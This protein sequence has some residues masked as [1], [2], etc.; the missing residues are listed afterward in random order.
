[1][2]ICSLCKSPMYGSIL[3]IYWYIKLLLKQSVTTCSVVCYFSINVILLDSCS[4]S[5]EFS[6]CTITQVLQI[7]SKCRFGALLVFYQQ[8]ASCS[9]CT[10]ESLRLTAHVWSHGQYHASGSHGMWSREEK[11]SK[12]T[13]RT[14][15]SLKYALMILTSSQEMLLLWQTVQSGVGGRKWGWHVCIEEGGE[16]PE[17]NVPT[18]NVRAEPVSAACSSRFVTNLQDF[19]FWGV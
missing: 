15:R 9:L 11:P 5:V 4:S 16:P 13:I 6:S 19:H 17:R 3:R 2:L 14:L 10:E 7:V 18:L 12:I 8:S 1:M